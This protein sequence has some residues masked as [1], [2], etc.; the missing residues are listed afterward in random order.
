MTPQCKPQRKRYSTRCAKEFVQFLIAAF[1]LVCFLRPLP[2]C[3]GVRGAL[4][5]AVQQ[6]APVCPSF[7]IT[8]CGVTNGVTKIQEC[9]R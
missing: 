8:R 1:D 3:G 4:P 2:L 9:Y 5:F 7:R 6:K